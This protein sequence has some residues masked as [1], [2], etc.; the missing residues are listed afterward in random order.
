MRESEYGGYVPYKRDMKNESYYLIP[1]QVRSILSLETEN[2]KTLRRKAE[3]F[4][5]LPQILRERRTFE[6]NEG[7]C[8]RKSRQRLPQR[9]NTGRQLRIVQPVR[10]QYL[11]VVGDKCDFVTVVVK[12]TVGCKYMLDGAGVKYRTFEDR[13]FTMRNVQENVFC[14]SFP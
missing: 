6:P 9:Q 7:H 1:E 2:M 3:S 5:V 11:L 4:H 8:P 10:P 13:V 14:P 12:D